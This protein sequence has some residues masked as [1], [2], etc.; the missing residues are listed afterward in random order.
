M[1]ENLMI[2]MQGEV[3]EVDEGRKTPRSTEE[4]AFVE[5]LKKRRVLESSVRY[6]RH[7]AGEIQVLVD[8]YASEKTIFYIEN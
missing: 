4:D 6:S 5:E 8:T 7:H 2:P 3:I 1:S